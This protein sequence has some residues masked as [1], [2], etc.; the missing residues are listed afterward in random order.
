MSS[1][2]K[3]GLAILGLLSFLDLIGPLVTDGENPP[4]EVALV[5][6]AIGL[7]SLVLIWYVV[8]GATRAVAP[9]GA[10][11]LLSAVAAAPAFFVDD[12]PVGIVALAGALVA[13]S[14]IGVA[15]VLRPLPVREEV[16][17]R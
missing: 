7:A 6:A 10:L 14:V 5:G 2:R 1:S 8:R 9:L 4:M 17:V 16:A 3:T 11:R 12:V 15:L 13:L